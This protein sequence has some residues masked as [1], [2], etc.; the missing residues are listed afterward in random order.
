[1]G[2]FGMTAVLG[3]VGFG[4][5]VTQCAPSSPPAPTAQERV[6]ALTNQQRAANGLGPVVINASLT[7]AAQAHANDGAASN[8]LSHT[9][10]DGSNGAVRIQ[11]T[12]YPVHFWGENVGAG[13]PTADQV[14]AEWMAS[15][16]HRANIVSGNFT[17]IGIGLAYSADGRAYWTMELARPW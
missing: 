10:S 1:M 8:S 6:V 2:A 17:E 9:G 5:L 14:V 7:A 12:G 11:R 15:P 4:A 16:A 13:Q 3:A